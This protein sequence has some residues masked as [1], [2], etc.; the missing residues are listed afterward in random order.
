V[1]GAAPQR[2]REPSQTELCAR[3]LVDLLAE[4]GEP[5]PPREVVTL[6]GQAGFKR[7]VVYRARKNLEGTIV[8]TDS[9]RSPRN[10]WSLAQSETD[11]NPGG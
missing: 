2:Y 7:S 1:Y 8:D 9:W 3:W 4:A 6:A 11:G 10:R 5:L